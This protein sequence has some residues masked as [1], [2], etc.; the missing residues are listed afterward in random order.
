MFQQWRE[1]AGYLIRW[2]RSER[3][4]L[5][6]SETDSARLREILGSATEYQRVEA[7][8]DRKRW[9]SGGLMLLFTA[10]LIAVLI[11]CARRLTR[12]WSVQAPA[13]YPMG[14]QQAV[15]K[16]QPASFPFWPVVKT[17]ETDDPRVLL[18]TSVSSRASRRTSGATRD[19]REAMIVQPIGDKKTIAPR[20]SL[21][22]FTAAYALL[23]WLSK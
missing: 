2:S 9:L 7:S 16:S 21:R 14:S 6:L 5:E 20:R 17:A 18:Y 3:L 4:I 11:V 13:T 10:V 23:M 19:Q 15:D 8:Q 22:A 1:S 12:N